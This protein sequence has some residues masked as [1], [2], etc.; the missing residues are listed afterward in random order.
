MNI[1]PLDVIGLIGL[2]V[3][4]GVSIYFWE[5]TAFRFV[6]FMYATTFTLGWFDNPSGSIVELL[7]AVA[8][9]NLVTGGMLFAAWLQIRR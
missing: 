8:V 3:A 1:E 2:F 5:R 4:L 7:K 9:M 6:P